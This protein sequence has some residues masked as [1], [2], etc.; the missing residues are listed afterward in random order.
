MNILGVFGSYAMEEQNEASDVDILV[1]I[2]KPIGLKFFKLWDELENLLGMK[3]D[4]L[5]IRAVKEKSLLWK[6]IKENLVYV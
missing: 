1:E 6:S 5:T 3:V 4:L 2:E